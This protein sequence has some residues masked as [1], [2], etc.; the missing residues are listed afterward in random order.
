[1]IIYQRNQKNCV[2]S[3]PVSANEKAYIDTKSGDK[4]CQSKEKAQHASKLWSSGLNRIL[5]K[6]LL[7]GHGFENAGL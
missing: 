3:C 5:G 2:V 4:P 7:G 6:S 1:M